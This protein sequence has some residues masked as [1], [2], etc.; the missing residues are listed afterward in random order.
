MITALITQTQTF[1]AIGPADWL[2]GAP[3][4]CVAAGILLAILAEV[5]PSLSPI[6]PVAFAGS[7]IAALFFEFKLL[8]EPQG[9]IFQGA[10]SA[11]TTSSFWGVL[12]LFSGLLAWLYG[13]RYYK[14]EAPFKAEHDILMLCSVLGML[15]MAG[16]EDLLTFFVGLEL[17]S[18]PLYA[19]ASFRRARQESVEAGMRYFLLGAF[20]V[21]LFLYG[22]ALI[23]VETGTI[24]LAGLQAEGIHSKL[25]LLGTTLVAASL[26]FK[27]SVFPF[28]FWVPDVYQGSP[29]PVT[30]FMS[31]G[32]KAAGFAF[33]FKIAFL[34]PP[35]AMATLAVIS[36]ITMSIGNLGALVQSD[37]K[38]MLGYSAVAHAGTLLLAITAGLAGDGQADGPIH[39][40]LYYM[41]AY[42]F[43]AAGAFGIIAT[44]EGDGEQF[45]KVES[46]RGLGQRRPWLAS[47]LSLFMLSL[48]GFPITG[49][50]FGKYF[51]FA[52]TLR[53]DLVAVSVI[54]VLLS[55]VALGYYLR[56]ILTM[57]M[58]PEIEGS[59]SPRAYR[60]SAS[61]ATVLCAVMVLALGLAPGWFLGRF[62]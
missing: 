21:G 20:A 38:R 27:I 8:A 45:T 37:L 58:Q 32:T 33:L 52:S 25:G 31:T 23:Y 7:L 14:L 26:L 12:F 5:V 61:F 39:A 42:V 30:T 46:L 57:W 40:A 59:V 22:T 50:F 34:F 47:A 19:L 35:G 36:I 53:A 11:D 13:Q 62:F 18:I 6:R 10:F 24:T 44:L 15:L 17:L 9:A 48:A 16:A 2:G 28:H 1:Q 55:V 49:G 29:T 51:I 3:M 56:I 43:S 60:P 4:L 41:A 54:G